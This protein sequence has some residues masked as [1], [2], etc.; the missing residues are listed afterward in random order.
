MIEIESEEGTGSTFR[1]VLPLA[2]PSGG[3]MIGSSR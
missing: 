3:A 1:V 2:R